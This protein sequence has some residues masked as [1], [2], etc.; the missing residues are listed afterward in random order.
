MK[1]KIF[2]VFR[3]GYPEPFAEIEGTEEEVVLF[4]RENKLQWSTFH[5]GHE[6]W[7]RHSG[8]GDKQ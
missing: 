7:C 3:W 1:Q 6:R 5:S 2:F 8:A 4:C